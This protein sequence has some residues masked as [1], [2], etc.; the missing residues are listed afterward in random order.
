LL[1]PHGAYARNVDVEYSIRSLNDLSTFYKALVRTGVANELHEGAS[2]TVLAPTDA[3]FADL[4]RENYPCF[5]QPQCHD[6]A[7]AFV[8]AHILEGRHP[9]KEIAQQSRIETISKQWLRTGEPYVNV[10]DVND[11]RVL[12]EAEVGENIVYRLDGFVVPD[13]DLTIF[14]TASAEQQTVEDP[15]ETIETRTTT[16]YVTPAEDADVNSHNLALPGTDQDQTTIRKTTTTKIFDQ[17][18]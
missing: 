15:V 14:R 11:A 12:S 13:T 3:A 1:P 2:Y 17:Q 7:A 4:T 10:Y 16:T 9:L 5:Y 6:Y 8:R 18:R